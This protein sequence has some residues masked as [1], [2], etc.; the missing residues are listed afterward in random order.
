[1]HLKARIMIK[2]FSLVSQ[3]LHK[4]LTLVSKI[5]VVVDMHLKARIMAYV[6]YTCKPNSA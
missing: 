3:I 4:V 6:T 5:S 1:M 2:L